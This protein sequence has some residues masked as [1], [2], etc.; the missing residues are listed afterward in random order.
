MVRWAQDR[1]EHG[2][3]PL[4]GWYPYLGLGSPRF[5]HYQVLPHIL[6]GYLA[7][8]TGAGTA[9]RW[10]LYLL[11]ASWP[12]SVYLGARFMGLGRWQA[13]AS[14]LVSPLVASAPGLGYEHGSYT[15]QGYGVW[16][17]LW[18]MWLLPLT[19]GVTWRAV[20]R[21]KWLAWAALLL[22]ATMTSHVLAGYLAFLSLGVWA[23][24]VRRVFLR[25]A[26]RAVV[27]ATAG[28]LVAAWL[29]VPL[30]ADTKWTNQSIFL[31]NRVYRDSFGAPQVL[32]WLFTGEIYDRGRFPILTLLVAVGLARSVMRLRDERGRAVMGVWLVSLLLFFGRPSLGAII[33]LLPAGGDLFLR[34]FIMGVHLTGLLLAGIGLAWLGEILIRLARSRLQRVRPAAL[35]V[36]IAT[37]ALLALSPAWLERVNYDARG[38]RLI[39]TQLRADRTD[40]ADV[41]ALVKRAKLLGGGR[42][43]AGLRSNWGQ[44]YRVGFVP[45]FAVLANLEADAVG[46]TLRTPSLSTDI[47]AL[48]EESNIDHYNLYNVRYLLL[49]EDH[50]PPVDADLV[51]RKGR[52]GLWQVETTGYLQVVDTTAPIEAHRHDLAV[53]MGQWLRSDLPGRSVH[54]TVGFEGEPPGP[55]T[56]LARGSLD[57]S[58]GTV[59]AQ[60]ALPVDGVFSG[61]VVANRT[62]VVLLKATFDPRW[63][64]VVDGI[65]GRPL[66]VAPSYVG[67]AVPPG[68]HSVL[69]RYHPVEG[70]PLLF[71][72]GGAALAALGP[73]PRL[74]KRARSTWIRRSARETAPAK[75]SPPRPG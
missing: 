41:A 64:V 75:R 52:H 2:H 8:A 28:L 3:V 66:M 25:R 49:P 56:L 50:D 63:E 20:D 27:V 59:E 74:L 9:Y 46:F 47:E 18:A 43:Y 51:A 12:I 29:L 1:I 68:R 30:L 24:V 11:L 34:R 32:D 35:A 10:V 33:D 26:L 44:T 65:T 73:G 69:F 70:Y 19:W 21:G 4:D 45:V 36:G 53:Q 23:V 15:W 31:R 7:G 67:V 42:I 6:T 48:F 71:L 16:S 61:Q 58:P 40:G 17:Q 55:R 62:A 38:G 14:A 39:G 54:P 13:G 22:A 37:I 57:N 72:V 5:H 60:S